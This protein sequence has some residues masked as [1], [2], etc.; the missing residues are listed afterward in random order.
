V[1]IPI[2]KGIESLNISN[3]AAVA[4]YELARRS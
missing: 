2:A 4:L 1:R 3:A